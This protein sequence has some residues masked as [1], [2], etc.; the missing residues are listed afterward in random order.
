MSKP[1]RYTV[2]LAEHPDLVVIYLG[3][4]VEEPRGLETLQR[5]GPQIQA[6]VEERPDGLLLHENLTYSEEPLHVGMRQYWR[7]HDALE[8]WSLRSRTRRGGRT[9]FVTV[10]EPRSG[11]RRI[12]GAAASR[13]C[14]ST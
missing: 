6:A 1:E 7:D 12:F 3:M 4:R 9:T 2:D 10:A 11:T 8:A 14:T 5:L 13:R